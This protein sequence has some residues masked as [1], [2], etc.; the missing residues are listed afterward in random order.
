MHDPLD[1][2]RTA[3]RRRT[4]QLFLLGLLTW[5][6][7]SSLVPRHGWDK[8]LGPVVPHDTFP[9][10][11]SLCHTGSDWHTLRAD[12]AFDHEA[13][14]GDGGIAVGVASFHEQELEPE[15]LLLLA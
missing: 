7:C 6:A 12:F 5:V 1:G 9:D 8:S 3:R 15:Q 2:G 13:R 11:C 10:D 14:T 4:G